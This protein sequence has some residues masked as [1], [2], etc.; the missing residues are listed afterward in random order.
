MR[1]PQPRIPFIFEWNSSGELIKFKALGVKIR[2]SSCQQSYCYAGSVDV[3][4]SKTLFTKLGGDT[5]HCFP[6]ERY[7]SCHTIHI[8]TW[9]SSYL[10][11]F[12]CDKR[13]SHLII[14]LRHGLNAD[15]SY[16]WC[17]RLPDHLVIATTIT[18]FHA[19]V[20]FGHCVV[21]VRY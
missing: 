1:G 10:G 4:I 12:C 7:E 18:I 19:L 6:N 9:Q 21:F 2:G 3:Q 16:N 5:N 8:I 13:S 15:P 17:R 11:L 14:S 20:G